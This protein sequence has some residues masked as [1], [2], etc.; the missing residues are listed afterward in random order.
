MN[1]LQPPSRFAKGASPH[2]RVHVWALIVTR[3]PHWHGALLAMHAHAAATGGP[4]VRGDRAPQL[5]RRA[6][7]PQQRAPL[8]TQTWLVKT[9]KLLSSAQW[10]MCQHNAP[11]LVPKGK[12]HRNTHCEETAA[13]WGGSEVQGQGHANQGFAR[14]VRA[15]IGWM[16]QTYAVPQPTSL[17]CCTAPATEHARICTNTP[18]A[19]TPCKL[20]MH[21]TRPHRP[22]TSA[23]WWGR[24]SQLPRHKTSPPTALGEG[25]LWVESCITA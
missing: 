24:L 22:A 12:W 6:G 21:A 17:L 7:A 16:R 3:K 19:C 5:H 10:G 8:V 13:G 9:K 25:R 4:P 23:C 18:C 2:A 1:S 15:G 14:L 20:P 11:R